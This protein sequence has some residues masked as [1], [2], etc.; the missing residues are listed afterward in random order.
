M[1]LQIRYAASAVAYVFVL[2]YVAA[3]VF[4]CQRPWHA[5]LLR[6]AVRAFGVANV[7]ASWQMMNVGKLLNGRRSVHAA[8][9][10]RCSDYERAAEKR[11]AVQHAQATA[12]LSC[13]Q[14]PGGVHD[15]M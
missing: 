10:L 8:L 7:R 9:C 14:T 12:Q 6:V 5:N 3:S 4:A 11:T 15:A 1:Y 2:V 13:T